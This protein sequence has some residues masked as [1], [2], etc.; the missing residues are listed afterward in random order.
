MLFSICSMRSTYRATDYVP[1]QGGTS[2]SRTPP[3]EY[4]IAS[5]SSFTKQVASA[6]TSTVVSL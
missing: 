6:A 4:V 3:E 2:R 1:Q 5:H